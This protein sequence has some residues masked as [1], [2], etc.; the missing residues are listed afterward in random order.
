MSKE[1]EG[2]IWQKNTRYFVQNIY[3]WGERGFMEKDFA[4]DVN[5]ES[6]YYDAILIGGTED[7]ICVLMRKKK[8]G[9]ML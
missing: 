5:K 2:I 9:K 8:T 4:K 1:K 7:R 6:D 3:L